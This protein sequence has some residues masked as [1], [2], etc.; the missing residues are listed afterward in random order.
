MLVGGIIRAFRPWILA[1]I[2]VMGVASAAAADGRRV[3]LVIGNGEYG[4]LPRLANPPRDAVL[5]AAKLRSI[6]F[7]VDVAL[8]DTQ[9]SLI[10][11]VR[12]F[13][14]RARDADVALFYY[15]GHG[16]Q[17][18][19]SNFLLPVDVKFRR[20][21][22]LHTQ[23]LPLSM[24]STALDS[25]DAKVSLIILDACRDNPLPRLL[26]SLSGT[27]SVK[28]N[29]GL[30]SLQRA[31]G[32]L[33]A[34]ATA[35]GD[36]AYDGAGEQNSPFTQAVAD[37]IDEPGLEVGTMFQQVREQVMAAT[38]G[39]QVPWI[40]EAILGD[41]YFQPPSV[42]VAPPASAIAAL[43]LEAASLPANV[44]EKQAGIEP[45][46]PP[47]AQ[48]T[49]QVETAWSK[50][51]AL[52]TRDAYVDFLEK[53]PKSDHAQEAVAKLLQFASTAALTLKPQEPAVTTPKVTATPKPAPPPSPPLPQAD[54]PI[55]VAWSNA[56]ASGTRDAYVRF[57]E[58]Y[59]NSDYA[60]D[61]VSML[62]QF[63]SPSAPAL[64]SQAT[65][66]QQ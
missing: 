18:R 14:L 24:V 37:L 5:M 51:K 50:A 44:P 15:A 33:V 20:Y 64:P 41:F 19:G 57:L 55:E 62:L 7:E 26:A 6:G 13:G 10:G 39:K 28:A 66:V 34:Y 53:H 61:A 52:G 45:S 43:S 65:A 8:D 1:A 9:A 30:A 40:D 25:A 36:V 58:Q 23:S 59:P 4:D 2:M 49:D 46:R 22:D 11:R 47:F 60:R 17:S 31:S 27:R 3:A 29:R 35:P 12:S 16:I 48:P 21:D 32:R 56:K 54:D 42:Q 63:A 38:D